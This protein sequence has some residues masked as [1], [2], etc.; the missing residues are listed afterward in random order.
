[1]IAV[2]LDWQPLTASMLLQKGLPPSSGF[3]AFVTMNRH[4][5]FS[6]L[7]TQAPQRLTLRSGRLNGHLLFFKNEIVDHET[8]LS[9]CQLDQVC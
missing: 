1:M 7:L 3:S 2:Q 4:P 6:P 9:N 8:N 5:L